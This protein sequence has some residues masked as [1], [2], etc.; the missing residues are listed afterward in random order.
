MNNAIESVATITVFGISFSQDRVRQMVVGDDFRTI[1]FMLTTKADDL[2]GVELKK[3]YDSNPKDKSLTIKD[4]ITREVNLHADE[5][6]KME[7]NMFLHY[8]VG[9]V[10]RVIFTLKNPI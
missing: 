7:Y 9:L 3:V 10:E 8:G 2:I 1:E 5:V 6:T 4:E